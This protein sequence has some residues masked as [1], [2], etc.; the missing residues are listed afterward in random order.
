MDEG[1]KNDDVPIGNF[2][3]QDVKNAKDKTD[4]KSKAEVQFVLYPDLDALK[5]HEQA[6]VEDGSIVNLASQ[7]NALESPHNRPCSVKKNWF[8]KKVQEPMCALQSVVGAKYREAA[9]L[10][11]KLTDALE[12]LLK[13]CRVNGQ[14]IM[15]KYPNFYNGGYL[16][17]EEITDINDLEAF[18]SFLESNLMNVKFLSKWVKCEGPGKKQLQ[19]FTAGPAFSRDMKDNWNKKDMCTKLRKK[20]A[21]MLAEA[22]YRAL[23][24]AAGNSFRRNRQKC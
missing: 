22:Q 3:M 9:H 11:G 21:V 24:Q 12:D 6:E 19:V 18:T 14:P 20:C 8:C 16:I 5:M 15:E 10:Q 23:A 4:P 13:N 7:F 1:V 2:T 17:P